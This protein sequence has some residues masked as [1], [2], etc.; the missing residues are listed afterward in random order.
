MPLRP[1]SS[2]LLGI[3][4]AGVAAMVT[5]A[6]AA[7]PAAAGPVAQVASGVAN[8]VETH[9]SSPPPAPPAPPSPPSTPPRSCDVRDHRA[10]ETTYA[11]VAADQG[12]TEAG[13]A[14]GSASPGA[15]VLGPGRL[16]LYVGAGAVVGSDRAALGE[17]RGSMGWLGLAA[18]GIRYFDRVPA[19][20]GM[21]PSNVTLDLWAL[22]VSGRLWRGRLLDG[23]GGD[24]ELW[25]DGGLGATGSNTFD[26]IYGAAFAVRAEQPLRRQVRV[27]GQLRYYGLEDDVSAVEG[28][29]GLRAWFVSVGY[30]AVRFNVGPPIHGPEAGI[31]VRF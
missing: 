2:P 21:P 25:V 4:S 1:A 22:T 26:T 3:V 15:I 23:S 29:A 31:A 9:S 11:Y 18:S 6:L 24:T 19:T 5:L 30:R 7:R 13:W 20:K 12:L 16:D 28:W 17:V 8:K 14:D 27:V 10:G